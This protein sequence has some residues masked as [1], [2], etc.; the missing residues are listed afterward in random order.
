MLLAI[1]AGN[2]SIAV[3]AFRGK[4]LI[5]RGRIPTRGSGTTGLG[6]PR[7]AARYASALRS[8]LRSF[9]A[10]PGEVEGVVVSSVVPR[11][12]AALRR[13][14]KGLVRPR[15]LVVG[16]D[17]RAPVINR[18]R[19][20]GQVGQ[21]RLV[22]AAAACFLYRGPAIVVDFGTAVT[23]DLVT[24]RREYL[25]GFIVPGLEIA[26]EAL[27]A[28]TALLPKIALTPPREF[29][30]R[31]TRSSMRS[32]LFYGYGALCDGLVASLKRRHAPRAQVIATGGHAAMI[33]PFCRSLR[34]VNPDLTLQGLELT[35]RKSVAGKGNL[36]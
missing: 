9:H 22:N 7:A 19:V 29:L 31:D 30:G 17:V 3:G 36:P 11:A 13:A 28:R 26:L 32:G 6:E 25:G 21:D 18:Y 12:T 20:P 5:A 33:A 2:T 8:F 34:I 23:I 16:E 14:L 35:Y 27:A 4:R 24:R 15:L 1:D 10:A